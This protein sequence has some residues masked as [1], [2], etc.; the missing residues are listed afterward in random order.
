MRVYKNLSTIFIFLFLCCDVFAAQLL[1]DLKERKILLD[2]CEQNKLHLPLDY[3]VQCELN[4]HHYNSSAARNNYSRYSAIRKRQVRLAEFNLLHPGMGKTRFKDYHHVAKIINQFDVV[5]ATELIPLVVDD[6]ENN[7]AVMAFIKNTPKQIQSLE[8]EMNKLKISIEQSTRGTVTKRRTLKLLEKKVSQLRSDLKSAAGLFREPG[9]LKILHALHKL[10]QGKEWA[11]ILSPRGEGSSVTPTPELVG[12]FYRSSLVKPKVNNYCRRIRRYGR[13]API[14]CIVNMDQADMGINKKDVF[15]RR[16]FLAEFI[17][18]KFSFTLITSHILFDEPDDPR[19]QQQI[20]RK[21]FNVSDYRVLGTGASKDK[22]ARFAEVK[23][24][25][26]FVRRNLLNSPGQKDIIFMGDLNLELDNQFWPNVLNSW[27]DSQI[28]IAE[29]TS[30]STSRYLSNGEETFA[31]SSNYDHF[32]FNPKE[33]D[34]CLHPKSHKLNG[35]VFNFVSGKIA[36]SLNQTYQVRNSYG[37]RYKEIIRKFVSPYKN[38][39]SPILTI[40]SKSVSYGKYRMSSEGIVIDNI[41]NRDYIE[42]FAERILDSQLRAESYYSYFENLISD[43]YPIY[44]NCRT[45]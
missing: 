17:S 23:M 41:A 3:N 39:S 2:E 30:L 26:D 34:E 44:M 40:G 9:Y 13:A 31:K 18:G 24:T 32:I 42:K 21:A 20:L 7:D 12:Y 27:P 45:Y 33:T 11:L 36:H 1:S 14:A 16:P 8:K 15:S 38:G 43:H 29:E 35:G 22:Y 6:Q 5:A 10:P 28:Y 37:R 4:L 19:L 25:L